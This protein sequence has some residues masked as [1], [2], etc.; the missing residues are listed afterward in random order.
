MSCWKLTQMYLALVMLGDGRK[1]L[2]YGAAWLESP[3]ACSTAG[4]GV[5][6]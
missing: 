3:Q 4:G 1:D 5:D 2:S 6:E